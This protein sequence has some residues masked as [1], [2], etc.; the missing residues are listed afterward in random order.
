ME[1]KRFIYQ[2]FSVI[3]ILNLCSCEKQDS[4]NKPESFQDLSNKPESL[5]YF[6]PFKTTSVF[7]KAI[8][9]NATID[10]NSATMVSSLIEQS[11]QSFLISVKE[12]TVPV[13]FSDNSTP[14]VTVEFTA[15]W[16]P[17]NQMLDVPVPPFAEPD[18]EE[19]GHMV[20]VDEFSGCIYD[21]WQM[22]YKNG[23]W[24]AGWGNTLQLNSDGFFPKGFS[25]RGSGIELLQG[26]IWPQE[27]EAGEINHALIFS[28]DYTKSGGPV[29][30]ATESD[31]TSNAS[32]AIPEG[33]LI[34]LDPSLD[35]NALGL[36][37]YE[38]IIA[39]ALQKYGMYCADD[40]GGISLYAINPI[41]SKSNPYQNIWGDQTYIYLDKIPV[42]KFRVLTLPPQ[43]NNE[44]EIVNNSCAKFK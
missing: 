38:K 30:P 9:L 6:E 28:Y 35:L 24:L 26:L 8:P 39:K 43:T 34:Q 32:W 2:F 42:D 4:I 15:D 19:D 44:P 23:Y 16:A 3:I 41:S 1:K 22:R 20:I 13:Y 29:A 10:P 7:F 14:R 33:A 21:F 40:G 36:N 37:S 5:K 12:W 11:H 31:G 25:A 27:L 18:P 17:K